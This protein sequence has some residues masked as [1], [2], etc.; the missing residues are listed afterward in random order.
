MICRGL[1]IRGVIVSDKV[2]LEGKIRPDLKRK[3][4]WRISPDYFTANPKWRIN[5]EFYKDHPNGAYTVNMSF[6]EMSEALKQRTKPKK[7]FVKGQNR[8]NK[9]ENA[10]SV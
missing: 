6:N 4:Y 10:D 8:P 7:K 2:R 1:K 3:T 5:P 9:E